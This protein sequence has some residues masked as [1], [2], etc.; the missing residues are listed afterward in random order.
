MM[1]SDYYR[2][3]NVL[4]PQNF[5]HLRSH[6]FFVVGGGL[7]EGRGCGGKLGSYKY[8]HF[9]EEQTKVANLDP[10]LFGRILFRLRIRLINVI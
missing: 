4:N 3:L 10:N 8:I 7:Y 5:R 1:P 9:L 6:N 2:S